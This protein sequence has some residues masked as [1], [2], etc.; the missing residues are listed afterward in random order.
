MKR[1]ECWVEIRRGLR[2]RKNNFRLDSNLEKIREKSILILGS[3]CGP[4][5]VSHMGSHV[6]IVLTIAC[7]TKQGGDGRGMHELW[8]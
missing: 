8:T 1:I 2:L 3:K 5:L 7:P 4:K 6:S